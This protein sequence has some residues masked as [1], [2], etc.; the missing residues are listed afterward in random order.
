MSSLWCRDVH[1]LPKFL[2]ILLKFSIMPTE[3][4]EAFGLYDFDARDHDELSFKK[5]SLLTVMKDQEDVQWVLGYQAG[6]GGL[7]PNNYIQN[8]GP[9]VSQVES[10]SLLSGRGSTSCVPPLWEGQPLVSAEGH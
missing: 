6:K 2:P 3:D 8:E 4:M 7:I 9:P 1:I 5:G 10:P